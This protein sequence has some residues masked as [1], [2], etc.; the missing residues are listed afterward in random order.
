MVPIQQPNAS[1]AQTPA[2]DSK[3]LPSWP[4]FAN[5]EIEAAAGV[6]RSGRVNYW[7]G[8]EGRLFEQEFAASIGCKYAVAVANGTV[9]LELALRALGVGPG[10]EVITSSRTF[11]A[12][13][14]SIV[15][16]GARPV[17]ADV[18]ANSQCITAD[19]IRSAV[20]GKTKAILVVHLGGWPC[21]MDPILAF[22]RE[23]GIRV[24]EDCGQA[25]G[26]I[27]KNKRVGSFGDVAAFSFCQDKI[28][29]TAGE[30]GMV[31]TDVEA[32]YRFMWSYKDHGK[33]FD[34]ANPA[35]PK[36]GFRWLH[37]S[38]GSNFRLSEV[39]SA[40]GRIQLAKLLAWLAIRR[41]NAEYLTARLSKVSGLRVPVLNPGIEPAWY[42]FYAFVDTSALLPGWDRDRIASEITAQGI[43]CSTGSC[44]EVYL[45]KAFPH[46]WQ[47]APRLAT[48][49][50]LGHASLMFLVHPTL[51]QAHMEQ[52]CQAVERVME[53]AT[54]INSKASTF[55]SDPPD[56]RPDDHPRLKQLLSPSPAPPPSLE[57]VQE[58]QGRVIMVTGA[59]GSVGSEL[60]RQL[61]RCA[62]AKLICLDQ[63]ETPLFHLQQALISTAETE[64]VYSVDDV[65]DTNNMRRLLAMHGVQCIFHAAAYKHV[66]LM[67]SN[68]SSALQ[69]NVFALL[70]L[71]DAAEACG[72][73]HLVFISSDK[74]VNP[75]SVMGCTKRLG[76]M[77]VGSRPQGHMRSFSVR[78]G[79]VLGSQGSVLPIFEQQIRNGGPITITHPEMTRYFITT[80][81]SASLMME[82]F[83]VA[84]RHDI[85]VLDM[86]N[87]ICIMDLARTLTRIAG[88]SE[89][90]VPIVYTGVR[91]G[92]KLQ[93]KMFYSS[94]SLSPTRVA[95][96]LKAQGNLPTWP[97]LSRHLS[98]LQEAAVTGSPD[99]IR[100]KLKQIIAE[101]V[102]HPL[103]VGELTPAE[104]AA[105]AED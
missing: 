7:T 17:F 75:G 88:R 64:I 1:Q 46:A 93:E 32:L 19:T 41:T 52:T 2:A 63:A 101:Y 103:Q 3:V 96:I 100:I 54:G 31:T 4:H 27:Y 23:R 77:I 89:H 60:C 11:I 42:K 36:T 91:P 79:N 72:C 10:D 28:I 24:I 86:D 39:Q 84:D 67:E 51:A 53:R 29:T 70:D 21:D 15:T 22:A 74:A 98:E 34:A 73:E 8:N 47:P 83:T 85:L 66:P 33:S 61:L 14:S 50:L 65:I 95:K 102:P 56:P 58:L 78:F 87:P 16:V 26:A 9:A 69:N 104:A 40:V 76:E 97:V 105:D 45:E 25:H 6:L 59:A 12:T 48:A 13:A 82:A 71:L 80:P 55:V 68:P 49:R 62:P 44:S 99:R 90:D 38:F 18:D 30:G 5:D 35:A 94:E 37:D 57:V 20:S 43:P 81:E 92:E